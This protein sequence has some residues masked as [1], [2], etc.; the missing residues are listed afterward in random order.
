[1]RGEAEAKLGPEEAF[2]R[3]GVDDEMVAAYTVAATETIQQDE[4][5]EWW[6]YVPSKFVRACPTVN[7]YSAVKRCENSRTTLR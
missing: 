4:G 5:D 1:M 6:R 3:R 2:S 7:L